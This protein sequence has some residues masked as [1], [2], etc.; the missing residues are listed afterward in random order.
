[1]PQRVLG[2]LAWIGFLGAAAVACDQGE[3]LISAPAGTLAPTDPAGAGAS[4]TVMGEGDVRPANP[5]ASDG[6]ALPSNVDVPLEG[7]VTPGEAG[8]TG[9]MT[10][11]PPEVIEP[12]WSD[13]L[14]VCPP[15]EDYPV[16][17]YAVT[18]Q[19]HVDE[20]EGCERIDADFTIFPFDGADLRPLRALREV[21]G[22]LTIGDGYTGY[23]HGFPSLEGLEGLRRVRGL[24]LSGIQARDL[25]VFRNLQR[26]DDPERN[27][28]FSGYSLEIFEA[29]NL[30][31]LKGLENVRGIYSLRVAGSPVFRSLQ[32]ARLTPHPN[33]FGGA[34]IVNSPVEDF[35]DVSSQTHLDFLWLSETPLQSLEP[36]QSL[37]S[38]GR[39]VI[40]RNPELVNATTL[41]RLESLQRL[42]LTANPKLTT[43][44]DL[45]LVHSPLAVSVRANAVLTHPPGFPRVTAL[46]TLVVVDNPALERLDSF[47]AL[48]QL[49]NGRISRNGRLMGFNLGSL[50]DVTGTLH[51]SDNPELDA[52][53]LAVVQGRIKR[54]G[55]RDPV[56]TLLSPCP[57]TDD[58][59]CDEPPWS[60][61]CAPGTDPICALD[62]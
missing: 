60:E 45:P 44:P 33:G 42:E 57:W 13:D 19:N 54:S 3:R 18:R 5:V 48:V 7:E 20:F 29:E 8:I 4:I 35:A 23:P 28:N 38:V 17:G 31:D 21:R 41:A 43:L 61:Y 26:V 12:E 50:V 46:P 30:V 52:S 37:R 24:T 15:A 25:A 34:V 27:P 53:S 14:R 9:T 1:M 36:F 22:R 40:D 6:D 2:Q 62:D 16:V 47:P 32:G 59:E 56:P 39:L 49:G 10:F 58:D 51:V 11:A 55:N